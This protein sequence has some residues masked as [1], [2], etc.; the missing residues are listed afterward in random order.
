MAIFDIFSKR[1]KKLRG[2]VPDIYVYDKLPESLRVQIVHIWR[3]T[4]GNEEQYHNV[5]DH[6]GENVRKSYSSLVNILCREYGIF[7]LP[8]VR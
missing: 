1:Q 8:G 3:D 4:I 6:I 7:H 5:Y 2:E